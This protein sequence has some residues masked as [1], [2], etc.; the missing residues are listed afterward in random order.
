MT[1]QTLESTT[2]L[3]FTRQR[4]AHQ[5]FARVA[6]PYRT[7]TSEETVM[8]VRELAAETLAAVTPSMPSIFGFFSG[9]GASLMTTAIG[10]GVANILHPFAATML[11]LGGL[12]LS[13]ASAVDLKY[14]RARV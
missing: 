3:A 11:F 12:V 5:T 4:I 8:D 9:V 1:T 7:S 10:L 2:T 13:I 6:P 14:W